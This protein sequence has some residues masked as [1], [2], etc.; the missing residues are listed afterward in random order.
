MF[1]D[2][3]SKIDSV[4]KVSL[5]DLYQRDW[6][7]YQKFTYLDG[8]EIEQW[9]DNIQHEFDLLVCFG[10]TPNSKLVDQFRSVQNNKVITYKCGNTSVLQME[11]LIFQNSYKD[12]ILNKEEKAPILEPIQFDEIWTIPQ[13]EFHNLQIWEVQHR[14]RTRV[15]P[16]IWSDKFVTQSISL[17]L[18]ENPDLVPYFDDKMDSIDRWRVATMEPNQN[19]IKNMYPMLWIFEY[20]NRLKSDLFEKFKITNA[21]EFQKNK[22]LI[23]LVHD[24]SFYQQGKL[25]LGP[26]WGVVNLLANEA[27]AIVSHQWG[28]PLNYAYFDVVYMGY[29]LVH[30]AHLCADIGYYYADWNVKDAGRLLVGACATRKNDKEYTNRNRDVLKRYTIH[31]NYMIEQYESLLNNLWEKNGIDNTA[32]DWKTNSIL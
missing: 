9:S 26:R 19:V 13:Q 12:H 25:Q 27:E 28:N 7:D 32:Y 18:N 3:L 29:P 16:F 30:N 15:V 17:A 10:I 6:E 31:N 8:Y 20:A 5:I 11:S 22:Y 14:T 21:L 2:L 4:T 24:L 1:Y 23:K